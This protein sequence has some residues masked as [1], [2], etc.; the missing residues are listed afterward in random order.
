ML[1]KLMGYILNSCGYVER[2]Q[3]NVAIYENDKLIRQIR[4]LKLSI[5]DLS[6]LNQIITEELKSTDDENK[7]LWTMLDEMKSSE[8]FGKEQ[9]KSMMED[10]NDIFTDEMMKDFKP[11][12]EA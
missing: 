3:Y 11:I 5:K 8:S 12:G 7:S 6:V 2:T 1:K 4:T 10:L 9:V